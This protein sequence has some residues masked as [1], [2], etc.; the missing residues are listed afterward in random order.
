MEKSGNKDLRDKIEF[1]KLKKDLIQRNIRDN[2][3][4][5]DILK[6]HDQELKDQVS[7]LDDEMQALSE[8]SD[9]ILTKYLIDNNI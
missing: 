7:K 5:I 3:M 1:L 9:D 8:E 4:Q 2:R 6:A